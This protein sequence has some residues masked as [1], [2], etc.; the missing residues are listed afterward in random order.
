MDMT[1]LHILSLV[2]IL[3]CCGTNEGSRLDQIKFAYRNPKIL[4][5][6]SHSR[7]SLDSLTKRLWGDKIMG[8]QMYNAYTL[9]RFKKLGICEIIAVET[10]ADDWDK[11]FLLTLDNN[12]Q[13]INYIEI[14]ESYGDA[15]SEDDETETV[16]SIGM[17]VEFLSDSTFARTRTNEITYSYQMPSQSIVMDSI[18]DYFVIN[19]SG[20]IQM[21]GKDSVRIK[22]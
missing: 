18:T 7:F 8:R 3:A 1:R 10:D 20:L 2:I 5:S 16:T 17:M 4:T 13:V 21:I 12:M 19:R 9:A 14:T 22:R 11:S 15:Y 6:E